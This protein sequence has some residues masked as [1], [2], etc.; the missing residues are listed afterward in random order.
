MDRKSL[1]IALP[2][3]SFLPSLGG[4]EIGLHNIC[5]KLVQK[6]HIPFVITSYSHEKKIKMMNLS[7]PYKVISLPPKFHLFLKKTLD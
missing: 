5:L 4:A 2:T 7:F 1:K 3:S 6:G